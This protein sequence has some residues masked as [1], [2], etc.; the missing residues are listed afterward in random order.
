MKAYKKYIL[1]LMLLM[2][3]LAS[4]AFAKPK[5]ASG[6]YNPTQLKETYKVDLRD[7][8]MSAPYADHILVMDEL[9]P[10]ATNNVLDAIQGRV[11]GVWVTRY[12]WNSYAFIRGYRSPLY[13]I[14]GMPVDVSAVNM[15]S[16]FD[17]ATI[18]VHKGLAPVMYGGRG[19]NGAIVINTKRG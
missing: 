19:G 8:S 12:G 13:V 11:P 6:V 16:P 18:E 10:V 2:V 14:D 1:G 3:T 9:P 15:I 4:G 17:V 7:I 5:K